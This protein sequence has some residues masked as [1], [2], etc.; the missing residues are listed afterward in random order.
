MSLHAVLRSCGIALLD[1][2]GKMVLFDE[3]KEFHEDM[4]EV[5][6]MVA[7]LYEAYAL[8]VFGRLAM[9][10]VR[11]S[12]LKGDLDESDLMV[13]HEGDLEKIAQEAKKLTQ[14]TM[15]ATCCILK[16]FMNPMRTEEP[17]SSGEDE[18]EFDPPEEG[19]GGHDDHSDDGGNMSVADLLGYIKGLADLG[20]KSF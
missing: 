10:V 1:P 13:E 19:H 9:K 3:V 15:N 18:E 8:L 6:F 4:Y 20:V 2:C 5:S 14:E 16:F 12:L 11:Q 17:V 7:D